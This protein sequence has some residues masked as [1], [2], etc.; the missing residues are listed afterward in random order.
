MFEATNQL[1]SHN[2]CIGRIFCRFGWNPNWMFWNFVFSL[3]WSRVVTCWNCRAVYHTISVFTMVFTET[4]QISVI[5]LCVERMLCKCAN[6]KFDEIR[7]RH[8]GLEKKRFKLL[9][10]LLPKKA[11]PK[12]PASLFVVLLR[13]LGFHVSTFVRR[14]WIRSMAGKIMGV[15][16]DCE[17]WFSCL[18]MTY[19]KKSS[20]FG[21]GC[22]TID[23]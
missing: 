20:I 14:L 21:S 19:S 17:I 12:K 2:W 22:F 9:S 10:Y 8:N 13:R 3:L 18:R 6:Q 16:I 5:L 23:S 7:P 11:R 4:W 15:P 1:V